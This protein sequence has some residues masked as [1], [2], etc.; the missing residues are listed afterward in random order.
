M[1][2]PRG[3]RGGL[4]TSSSPTQPKLNSHPGLIN[5]GPGPKPGSLPQ[6]TAA[7][8]R[9]HLNWAARHGPGQSR[10]ADSAVP[11]P[12]LQ[13]IQLG[14]PDTARPL[15]VAEIPDSRRSG[16]RPEERL[17]ADTPITGPDPPPPQSGSRAK[18]FSLSPA[19]AA[20]PFRHG[21]PPGNSKKDQ[22]P[23]RQRAVPSGD[24]PT[25]WKK[26]PQVLPRLPHWTG[27]PRMAY[28]SSPL[29]AAPPS[30]GTHPVKGTDATSSQALGPTRSTTLSGSRARSLQPV[31][32]RGCAPSIHGPSPGTARRTKYMT[33]TTQLSESFP[34][35]FSNSH[36][37]RAGPLS[38]GNLRRPRSPAPATALKTRKVGR[39]CS[40]LNHTTAQASASAE[41]DVSGSTSHSA[42]LTG[43]A[44]YLTYRAPGPSAV[45]SMPQDP[46]TQ[47]ISPRIL[48][49]SLSAGWPSS[50]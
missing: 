16:S 3:R 29:R 47:V 37:P 25:P 38:L 20:L 50:Q 11:D 35:G 26:K 4:G 15:S 49:Q 14:P 13:T 24:G 21:A 40:C 48:E 46:A 9:S 44:R 36:Y 10:S 23:P 12:I 45:R 1:E 32:R 8:L 31:S 22:T 34:R 28:S 41:P 43:S 7:T 33:P 2:P 5:T 18:T 39:K 30:K 19:A 6:P 17:N 42:S 27:R